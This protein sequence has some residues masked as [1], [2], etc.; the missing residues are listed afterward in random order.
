MKNEVKNEFDEKIILQAIANVILE[1]DCCITL[2]E[3]VSK[4]K[5][6]VKGGK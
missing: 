4:E 2:D 3:V 1:E 6:L 5:I